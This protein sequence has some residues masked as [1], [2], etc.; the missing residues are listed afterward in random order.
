MRTV[1]CFPSTCRFVVVTVSVSALLEPVRLGGDGRRPSSIYILPWIE[2][3]HIAIAHHKAFLS[4]HGGIR[5]KKWDSLHCA[6]AEAEL[7]PHRD[8]WEVVEWSLG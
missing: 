1:A 8:K 5:P 3:R 4:L 6:V 7:A 2:F